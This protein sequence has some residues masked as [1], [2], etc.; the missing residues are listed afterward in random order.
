MDFITEGIQI[1]QK[2]LQK[3]KLDIFDVFT[4]S[5]VVARLCKQFSRF[6]IVNDLEKYAA[7]T[8]EC[9]LS[10]KDEID[11]SLLKEMYNGLL[12]QPC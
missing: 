12:V 3:D 10:N 1:V 8:G 5:G 9:Y 2:R 7:V 11:M 4:G 6:L